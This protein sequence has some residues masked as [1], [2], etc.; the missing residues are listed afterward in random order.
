MNIESGFTREEL[1]F[2]RQTVGRVIPASPVDGLPGADDEQ[3]F[4]VLLDTAIAKCDDLKKQM[5]DLVE[6]NGGLSRLLEIDE[7]EF[8]KQFAHWA[9]RWPENAHPFFGLLMP[10][11]LRAYYQDPRV[12]AAHGRRPGPPFP[13]GYVLIDGDWSLLDTVRKRPLLYR[14]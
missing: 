14:R 7:A 1:L 12:H 8:D 4:S 5:H 2:L 11:L 9:E 6:E 10:V 3:I 13:E